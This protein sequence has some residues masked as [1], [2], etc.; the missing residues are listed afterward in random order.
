MMPIFNRTGLERVRVVGPELGLL[1][2]DAEGSWIVE[3]VV[4]LLQ[5]WSAGFGCGSSLKKEQERRRAG[6]GFARGRSDA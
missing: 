2:T 1:W 3:A 4:G 6:R 5:C